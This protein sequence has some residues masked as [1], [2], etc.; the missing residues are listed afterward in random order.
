MK[1]CVISML[2]LSEDGKLAPKKN[3]KKQKQKE[4]ERIWDLQLKKSESERK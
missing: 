1:F 2:T 4:Q 3:N